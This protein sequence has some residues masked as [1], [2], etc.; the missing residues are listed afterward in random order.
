MVRAEH[1]GAIPG[2]VHGA[3]AS[4]A[5]LFLEPLGTVEINNDI[6]ELEEAGSRGSA[7]HPARADRRV[8]RAGPTTSSARFDVATELDI[9]QARARF[10]QMTGGVEPMIATDGTFELRGARHPLLRR[11]KARARRRRAVDPMTS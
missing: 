11:R 8:P 5:S 1:R 9:I 2:I 4:G 10:S 7:A 3:S 6:V